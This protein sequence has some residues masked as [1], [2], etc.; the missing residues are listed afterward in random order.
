M[1]TPQMNQ[2]A[3]D[4]AEFERWKDGLSLLHWAEGKDTGREAYKA[5][6]A[7]ERGR[8]KVL[9]EALERMYPNTEPRSYEIAREALSKYRG[10]SNDSDAAIENTQKYNNGYN[11]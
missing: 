7:A 11:K 10:E 6:L 3:Q 5:A 9:V 2:Q 1:N 8:S 4:E